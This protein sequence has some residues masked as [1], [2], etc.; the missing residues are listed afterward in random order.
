MQGASIENYMTL[1][2]EDV[3]VRHL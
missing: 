3:P 2:T 1:W